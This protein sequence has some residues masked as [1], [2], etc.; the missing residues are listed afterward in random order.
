M[1]SR[2][3]LSGAGLRRSLRNGSNQS[4][5][6]V[7]KG[8][9]YAYVSHASLTANRRGIAIITTGNSFHVMYNLPRT[10]C[11]C[12]CIDYL[13]IGNRQFARHIRDYSRT[14]TSSIEM[15]GLIY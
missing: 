2:R 6:K 8:V 4:R 9:Y 1:E 14:V 7:L 3:I 13:D 10:L 5:I 15:Y 11:I 12:S